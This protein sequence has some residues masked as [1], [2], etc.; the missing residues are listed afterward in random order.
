[1]S[2]VNCTVERVPSSKRLVRLETFAQR[3]QSLQP[4]AYVY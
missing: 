3:Q 1:M 2:A 4:Q